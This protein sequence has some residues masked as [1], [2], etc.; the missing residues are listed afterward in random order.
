MPSPSTDQ[1]EF[2]DLYITSSEICAT[3][4]VKRS[5]VVIARQRG[6]LPAPIV[7]QGCKIHIWKRRDVMPYVQAWEKQLKARR[8]ETS[9]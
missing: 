5:S 1:I 3:L 6:A 7:V 2:D 4:G 9:L 8:G